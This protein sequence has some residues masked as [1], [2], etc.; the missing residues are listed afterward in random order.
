[1]FRYHGFPGVGLCLEPTASCFNCR[2]KYAALGE[3]LQTFVMR[4]GG[5]GGSQRLTCHI[6]VDRALVV[7]LVAVR[8]GE[9][10]GVLGPGAAHRQQAAV[11]LSGPAT[12]RLHHLHLIARQT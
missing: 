8:A 4:S 3:G 11:L 7:G 1:M 10:A 2:S 9:Q 6:H 12:A 5:G